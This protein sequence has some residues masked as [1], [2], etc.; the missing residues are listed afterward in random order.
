[1]ALKL[2]AAMAGPNVLTGFIEAPV[3]CLQ[4]DQN[5]KFLVCFFFGEGEVVHKS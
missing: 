5:E 1:M 3:V 2:F 4:H